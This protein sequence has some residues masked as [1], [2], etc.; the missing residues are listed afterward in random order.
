MALIARAH[1]ELEWPKTCSH[2]PPLVY[3]GLIVLK[4]SYS[5]SRKC[6]PFPSNACFP[7]V[8]NVVTIR[9]LAI[10]PRYFAW[11]GGSRIEW[12]GIFVDILI[13]SLF[14]ATRAF[15]KFNGIFMI[16]VKEM[17]QFA[18]NGRRVR[19]EWMRF[20]V[21]YFLRSMD[22][23]S[24]NDDFWH[25]FFNAGLIDAASNSEQFCFHACY[26]CCVM[27]YFDERMIGWMYVRY[28][29]SNIVLDAS[30]CYDEGCR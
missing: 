10:I 13:K 30:I 11:V 14:E 22:G 21:K 18:K 23:I 3:A 17:T 19:L 9:F 8:N 27:N 7:L 4:L 12:L 16:F 28:R 6:F 5:K 24:D 26:E 2:S 1:S 29:S 20:A 25:V 15:P